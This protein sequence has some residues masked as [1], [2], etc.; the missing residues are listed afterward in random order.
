MKRIVTQLIAA[1][2]QIVFLH[3]A[4]AAGAD[5]RQDDTT[6]RLVAHVIAA[7]GGEKAIESVKGIHAVGEI[8]ALMRGDRGTYEYFF[9]R[10]GKLRVE[11]KYQRSSETRILNNGR[12]YRGADAQPPSEVTGPKLLAMVYQYKHIDLLYDLLKG[13]YSV[14]RRGRESI[15]GNPAD[16]LH[17]ADSEGPPMDVAVDAKTF[18]IVRVTGYFKMGEGETSLSSEFSEFRKT[19]GAVLPYRIVNYAGGQKIAETVM[20][21]YE[22][23]PALPGTL[24]MP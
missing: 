24:F 8:S 15:Q 19:G 2:V 9:Q 23:N 5:G 1:I 6:R 22:V 10:P 4:I 3:A 21:T 13:T 14:S 7:Y 11:T 17:L 12:G 16:V 20:K 18:Y